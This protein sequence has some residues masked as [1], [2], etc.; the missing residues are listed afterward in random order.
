MDGRSDRINVNTTCGW[1]AWLLHLPDRETE[2]KEKLR[3]YKSLDAY[4]CT[5][6]SRYVQDLCGS[7][8]SAVLP[9]Q[10]QGQTEDDNVKSDITVQ[11]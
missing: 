9:S 1:V 3:A 2:G 4:N 8:R 5:K 6:W 7:L 10:R 11:F